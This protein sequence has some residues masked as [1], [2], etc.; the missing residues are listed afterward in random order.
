MDD[1]AGIGRGATAL[2]RLD[3]AERPRRVVDGGEAERTRRGAGAALCRRLKTRRRSKRLCEVN[4]ENFIRPP[5]D[6]VAGDSQ[7]EPSMT[8]KQQQRRVK[9]TPS[10]DDNG[11]ETYKSSVVNLG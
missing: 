10:S 4:L 3:G 5:E 9:S 1:V 11:G 2:S 6:R 8:F 7:R